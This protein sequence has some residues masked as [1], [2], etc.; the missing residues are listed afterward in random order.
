MGDL[1]SN[2]HSFAATVTHPSHVSKAST[3]RFLHIVLLHMNKG[4]EYINMQ[5]D[6]RR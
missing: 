6:F 4:Y 2:N 1:H 5:L 3:P